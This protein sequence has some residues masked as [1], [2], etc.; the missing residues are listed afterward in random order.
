MSRIAEA[1][2]LQ[3]SPVA[4]YRTEEAP[5]H[6]IRFKP[7]V[8]NCVVALLHAAAR[9]RKTTAC[10]LETVACPG[11]RIGLGLQSFEPGF[12][13]HF[14]SE[15]WE[16]QRS[17]EHYKKSPAHALAY[18]Q[19]LPDVRT[20]HDLVF[21]PIEDLGDI[22]PEEIIFLVNADQMSALATL[23]NYD[24]MKQDNVKVLFGAGCMQSILLGL[25]QQE[26]GGNSCFI[27]LTDP[28]ARQCIEKDLLSFSIPYSRF[29]EMEASVDHSF[30]KTETWERIRKR[31]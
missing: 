25:E 18:Y 9:Q 12:L 2:K 5:E 29:L 15:G 31:I 28:S 13:E 14:L 17:G 10:S 1:I 21:C 7:G 11:G 26:A 19:G 30:L 4:V 27:G 8:W 16:G 23:A 24:S 6:A 20:P 22:I 3:G